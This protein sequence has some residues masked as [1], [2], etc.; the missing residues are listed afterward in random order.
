MQ[1]L[2]VGV[3][4]GGT[5]TKAVIQNDRGELIGVGQAGPGNI[6]TSAQGSFHSVKTAINEALH[7]AGIH[8]PQNY[9]LHVGLGMAGTEVPGAKAAFLQIPHSFHTLILNSDA[10]VACLG[11]HGGEDGAIIIIGTGV[12]GFQ[13]EQDKITRVSGYGFPHSDIGGGAWLGL[14]LLRATFQAYDGVGDWNPLCER[15]FNHF[16][17]NISKMTS[18]ANAAK[19]ANFGEFAPFVIEALEH[20][21]PFAI[22]LFE[23]AAWEINQLWNALVRKSTKSLPCCLLGGIAPFFMPYLSHQ[24]R[25]HIIKRKMDAPTGAILMLKQHMGIKS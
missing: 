19:P 14:E 13:I 2:F 11:V 6:Q 16:D 22:Q 1:N 10:Y 5:K 9:R 7:N 8:D 20:K 21:E 17:R 18:F 24:L 3:D 12:I 4:G 23:K 25:S 15:V